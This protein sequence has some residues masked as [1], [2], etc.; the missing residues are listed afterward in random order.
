VF[1]KIKEVNM[2]K[3]IILSLMLS[4]CGAMGIGKNKK[5]DIYNNSES[6]ITARGDY[7]VFKIEP[8]GSATVRSET[9]IAI[10]SSDKKCDSQEVPTQTNTTAIILDIFPGFL[11]LY[12]PLVIDAVTEG[13]KTLPSD[14]TYDC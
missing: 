12:V 10:V 1:G 11:L 5:V 9:N 8:K 7:G 13:Y 14:Y 4:S 3:L 2:K 6:E